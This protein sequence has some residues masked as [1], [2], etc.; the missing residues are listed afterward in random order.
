MDV[1]FEVR[2]P[3]IVLEQL[4]FN[5][6]KFGGHV[7]LATP[8]CEKFVRNYVWTVLGNTQVKFEIRSFEFRSLAG[9]YI[10]TGKHAVSPATDSH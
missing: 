8:L 9:P 5:A 2:I 6:Q 4:A 1:K 3:L 10:I 7:K